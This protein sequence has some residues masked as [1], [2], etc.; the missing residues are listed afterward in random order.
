MPRG[1]DVDHTGGAVFF[2]QQVA[3]VLFDDGGNG[4]VRCQN[5][6]ETIPQSAW[7]FGAAMSSP[8]WR[9]VVDFTP[10]ARM[11]AV[12]P[13]GPHPV[14][15]VCLLR[16]AHGRGHAPHLTIA[17]LSE[18][19]LDPGCG[20]VRSSAYWRVARPEGRLFNVAHVGRGCESGVE[21]P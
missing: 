20:D 10:L 7:C 11:R 1:L 16:L 2:H 6:G 9:I 19:D 14:A 5:H 4:D 13:P 17:P 12:E 21:P 3:S 8:R 15:H 18:S